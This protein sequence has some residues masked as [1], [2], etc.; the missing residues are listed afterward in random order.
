MHLQRQLARWHHDEAGRPGRDGALALPARGDESGA[1]QLG[2]AA[3]ERGQQVAQRLARSRL[4]D[5][6]QI[7]ARGGDRPCGA[8]DG[9]G[10]AE[11]WLRHELGDQGGR[12]GRVRQADARRRRVRVAQAHIVL[13]EP[14]GR[15]TAALGGLAAFEALLLRLWVRLRERPLRSTELSQA[16]AGTT[17]SGLLRRRRWRRWRWWRRRPRRRLP[18][19]LFCAQLLHPLPVG[20]FFR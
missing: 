2:Q 16:H 19:E 17:A 9:G 20:L 12:E 1:L 18:S 10:R 14:S 4:G 3:R 11:A 15:L 7:V 6:K 8:L 13:S 5:G